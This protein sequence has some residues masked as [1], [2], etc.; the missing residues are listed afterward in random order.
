MKRNAFA[1]TQT[2]ERNIVV[3]VVIVV[4]YRSFAFQ[5]NRKFSSLVLLNGHRTFV[6]MFFFFPFP[7][8][9]NQKAT[10]RILPDDYR[11]KS[12]YFFFSVE[13]EESAW[14]LLSSSRFVAEQSNT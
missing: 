9:Q 13:G 6:V 4:C 1:H 10:S 7:S 12:T 5:K 14:V 3:V 2:K 8:I 11:T